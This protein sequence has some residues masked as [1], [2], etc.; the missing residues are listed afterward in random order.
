LCHFFLN[1]IF[2]IKYTRFNKIKKPAK[3]PAEQK[4][5]PTAVLAASGQRVYS[6][7]Q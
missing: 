3:Q 7:A 4:I 1:D 6:Q 2:S 5:L